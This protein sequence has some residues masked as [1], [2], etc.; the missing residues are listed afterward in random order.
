MGMVCETDKGCYRECRIGEEHVADFSGLMPEAWLPVLARGP[1]I[2]KVPMGCVLKPLSSCGIEHRIHQATRPI[3][4][5]HLF[6]G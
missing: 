3:L 5:E 6:H 2:T 1:G 4:P